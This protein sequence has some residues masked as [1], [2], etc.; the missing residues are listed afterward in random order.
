MRVAGPAPETIW[1]PANTLVLNMPDTRKRFLLHGLVFGFYGL[2]AFLTLNLLILNGFDV[3]PYGSETDYYQS[4]WNFWW[5]RYALVELGQPV[6]WTTYLHVPFELNLAYHSLTLGWFPFYLL[7]EPVLGQI[8]TVNA[9]F[10]LTLVLNGYLTWLFLR[11]EGIPNDAALIGG[12]FPVTMQYITFHV[13]NSHLNVIAFFWVPLTALIW[14]R[15][16]RT[17]HLGWVVLLGV[18][19]WGMWLTG[20]QWLIWAPVFLVPYGISTL[21]GAK[22][23]KS[24]LVLVGL[25]L[26]AVIVLAALGWV[27]APV[28]AMLAYE[29]VVQPVELKTP[30]HWSLTPGGLF[31]FGGEQDQS[32]GH[33]LLPLAILALFVRR[34]AREWRRWLWLGAGLLVLLLALGPDITVGSLTIPL[35]YRWIHEASNGLYRTPVRFLAMALLALLL[36]VGS[37][38]RPWLDGLQ[39]GHRW[40]LM[41]GMVML[42]AVDGAIYRPAPVYAVPHYDLYE[43]IGQDTA[44]VVLVDVPLSVANGW[45]SYG[46]LRPEEQFYQITHRKRMVNGAVSREPTSNYLTYR[47]NPLWSWLAGQNALREEEAR[48][49]LARLVQEWPI[50]YVI[51]DQSYLGPNH[52][53][54]LDWVAFMNS[55]EHLC[56]FASETP[57]LAYRSTGHP[58]GCTFEPSSHVDLGTPADQG[59]VGFGWYW[60]EGIGGRTARWMGPNGALHLVPPASASTLVVE[61]IAFHQARQVTVSLDGQPLGTIEV[62]PGDWQRFELPVPPSDGSSRVALVFRAGSVDSP[63]E[64]GISPDER[65]LSIAVGS[66]SFE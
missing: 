49:E 11:A 26:L 25:G 29:G 42:L 52:P 8:L 6:F 16:A 5:T 57:L 51:V 56:L 30:R 43:A 47:N 55:D 15:V 59:L 66:V 63:A 33:V 10:W 48:A 65:M 1:L 64:L 60:P 44:D 18:A 9:M 37:S 38:V 54:T 2:L 12:M 53:Q 35:P 50:G 28:R 31:G 34:R 14:R 3:V 7:A 61:A 41:M 40:A 22:G 27:I 4:H 45:N 46:K 39:R 58:E 32:L 13:W 24:R 21:I 36:F 23:T 62:L 17:R 20:A 19:F